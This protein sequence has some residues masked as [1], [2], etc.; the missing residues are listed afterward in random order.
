MFSYFVLCA[1]GLSG[2]G[3]QLHVCWLCQ[4]ITCLNYAI[5]D[6]FLIYPFLSCNM[7]RSCGDQL[8]VFW[9]FA[10]E[11]IFLIRV[12]SSIGKRILIALNSLTRTLLFCSLS[13][14]PSL[15]LP[16]K[17]EHSIR[18]SAKTCVCVR[19][20]NYLHHLSACNSFVARS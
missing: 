7:T 17:L 3:A 12:R 6:L 16:R 19:S 20:P 15:A 1:C 2:P 9:F 11:T 4:A 18:T 10:F 8:S 5:S 14:S 13:I